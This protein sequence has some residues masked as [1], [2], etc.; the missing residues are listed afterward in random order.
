[1]E[2]AWIIILS[3]AL[4]LAVDSGQAQDR[5]SVEIAGSSAFAT[6]DLGDADLGTGAGFETTFAYR[7]LPHLAAYGGWGWHHFSAGT[8]FA[9]TDADF[10]E[11]GYVFGLQFTHPLRALPL[12][13]FVRAG[14]TYDHIEVEDGDDLSADTG[15]GFGWQA[16]AGLVLLRG[17]NWRLTPGIQYQSLSRDV[18]VNGV[19]TDLDLTY[20][21][22]RVGVVRTF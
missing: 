11:T 20:V 18:T 3:L 14:G 19:R 8:S 6:Q 21:S 1:M 12:D 4:L 5:F 22:L 15:H 13:Y 10:E 17:G 7:F 2:R 9:G 16:A